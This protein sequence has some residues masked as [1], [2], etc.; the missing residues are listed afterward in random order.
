MTKTMKAL[1][2]LSGGV[3]GKEFFP[4]SQA[5]PHSKNK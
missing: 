3:E 1:I 2:L 5:K 4:D